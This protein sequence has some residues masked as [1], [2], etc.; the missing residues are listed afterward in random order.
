MIDI[1]KLLGKNNDPNCNKKRQAET[2]WF[3]KPAGKKAVY[4]CR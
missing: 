1:Y 3:R 4:Y 2:F